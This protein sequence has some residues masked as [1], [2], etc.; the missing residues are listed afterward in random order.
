MRCD[1]IVKMKATLEDFDRLICAA[2]VKAAHPAE[3]SSLAAMAARLRD[4]YN[5]LLATDIDAGFNVQT[6]LL[7]VRYPPPRIIK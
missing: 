6:G 2:E 3:P 4:E 7:T 5:T 1:D